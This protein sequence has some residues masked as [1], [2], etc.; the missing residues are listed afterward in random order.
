MLKKQIRYKTWEKEK[1]KLKVGRKIVK[2]LVKDLNNI[3]I[4]N[5]FFDVV[6]L[7][8]GQIGSVPFTNYEYNMCICENGDTCK[9]L[10]QDASLRS[11]PP[12]YFNYVQTEVPL[13]LIA[14][15]QYNVLE[16]IYDE[17]FSFFFL[18]EIQQ[19]YTLLN[20]SIDLTH[21]YKKIKD[22]QNHSMYEEWDKLIQDIKPQYILCPKKEWQI[23]F[24]EVISSTN[25]KIVTPPDLNKLDNF[26]M[27]EELLK[28]FDNQI[29][30][31]TK[32][33]IGQSLLRI[34]LT[35]ISTDQFIFGK[36]C[37]GFMFVEQKSMTINSVNAIY[38]I[39]IE[40]STKR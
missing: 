10:K 27:S 38:K 12:E 15:R 30:F 9:K 20:A 35:V 17:A 16:K 2:R 34:P 19:L 26:Y 25:I 33:K 24:K 8:E 5:N 31:F 32:N 18:K 4:L 11:Y 1:S 40:T 22:I 3:S 23:I 13:S 39:D 21:N 37:Y 36:L 14:T 7:K 6:K 29:Y 28:P